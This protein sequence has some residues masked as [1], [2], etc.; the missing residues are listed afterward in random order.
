MS[1][2]QAAK[3]GRI[4]LIRDLLK[5]GIS[6][7]SQ[8]ADKSTALHYAASFQQEGVVRFLLENGV[9]VN[10]QNARG[11]TALHVAANS[12]NEIIIVLLLEASA[13]PNAKDN[14]VC[15]YTIAKK[16]GIKSRHIFAL[17]SKYVHKKR[18]NMNL[19]FQRL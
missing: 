6:I 19:L 17:L 12:G 1:I 14:G 7:D 13:D 11:L 16:N 4:D 18:K 3:E 5:R 9:S 15:I 10:I 2:F 8:T